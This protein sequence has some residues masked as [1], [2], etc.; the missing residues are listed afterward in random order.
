MLGAYV[1]PRAR[2]HLI[3]EQLGTFGQEVLPIHVSELDQISKAMGVFE[4]WE[5][6]DFCSIAKL[7]WLRNVQLFFK[8]G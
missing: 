2:L 3:F 1:P 7:R 8:V 6:E 5:L 4:I